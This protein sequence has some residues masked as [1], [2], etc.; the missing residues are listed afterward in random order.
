MATTRQ[1]VSPTPGDIKILELEL[2]PR[3]ED[4]S[5]NGFDD[6]YKQISMWSRASSQ[7]HNMIHEH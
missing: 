4:S 3:A 6:R 1:V 2:I 7:T 5:Y